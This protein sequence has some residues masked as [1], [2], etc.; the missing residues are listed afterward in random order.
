MT[1]SSQV[2]FLAT[3]E[4]L[5]II[6]STSATTI[7]AMV[8]LLL[9]IFPLYRVRLQSEEHQLYYPLVYSPLS[10]SRDVTVPLSIST[11]GAS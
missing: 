6:P 1:T 4:N 10:L 2:Q 5:F 7:S 9:N 8:K 11:V 3:V